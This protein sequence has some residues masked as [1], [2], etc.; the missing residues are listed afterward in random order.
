[1]GPQQQL[2]RSIA[3]KVSLSEI[4]TLPLIKEE[5]LG[6][7]YLQFG[8][9]QL[10]RV[11]IIGT[12]I[13]KQDNNMAATIEDGTSTIQLRVFEDRRLLQHVEVGDVTLAIGRPREYGAERY[14]LPEIIKKIDAGW[15][16]VRSK[17]LA[18]RKPLVI[19]QSVQGQA[20]ELEKSSQEMEEAMETPTEIIRNFIRQLDKGDGVDVESV[21]SSGITENAEKHLATLLKNGDIFEI[22]PGRV[23]VLE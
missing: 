8:E 15:L 17:E 20:Q 10:S 7:S 4:V 12:I 16:K 2:K 5:G 18:L 22:R 11:N 6:S 9:K 13:R 1:M 23:K 3:F 21:V 14:I 19:A